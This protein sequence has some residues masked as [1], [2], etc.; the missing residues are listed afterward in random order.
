MRVLEQLF[1]PFRR[2][3][4]TTKY[5]AE[6]PALDSRRSR[7]TPVRNA[8]ACTDDRACEAICPTSAIIVE[9]PEP[10]GNASSTPTWRLDYGLCIF[11]GECSRAC[12]TG[13]LTTTADFELAATSRSAAIAI[14]Q[15]PIVPGSTSADGKRRQGEEQ[16]F[17]VR[18]Q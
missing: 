12:S 1:A 8:D 17:G 16:R 10:A 9:D 13:A 7:G 6:R 4:V 15:Y 5:P 2:P 11:C 14:G 3:L 18:E